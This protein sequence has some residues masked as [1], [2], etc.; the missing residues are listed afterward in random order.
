M[1]STFL[2]VSLTLSEYHTS[3]SHP[4]EMLGQLRY[5]FFVTHAHD[6]FTQWARQY[7][8]IFSLKVFTRTI[9]VLSS[10]SAI[11]EILDTK[12]T[13]T[14]ARPY[15]ILVQRATNGSL[16]ALENP[17]N[18]IWK[19]GRK[20]ITSSFLSK[21]RLPT[22]LR[23]QKLES[24]HLM[25]DLLEDP[26]HVYDHIGRTTLSVLTSLLYGLRITKD[27]PL[28]PKTYFRSV[29]LLNEGLD[30]G[31]HP[32]VDSFWPL[33]YVP[34]Q[35]AYWKRFADSTRTIRDELYTSLHARC[36]LDIKNN[37]Q[38]G[39]YIESLILS[40][41]D[42]KLS[43]DDI[44]GLG[45]MILDAGVETSSSF[46]QSLM[47]SL[48]ANP[49][50]QS[51]AQAEIDRTVG[52]DRL[53]DIED[54]AHTP[55]IRALI[56]E[57]FRFCSILPVGL[58]HVAT[59]DISFK[60]Y[61][62]PRDS[63]IFMNVHGLYH[64]PALFD[65][66]ETF[67]PERFIGN[68]FGTKSDISETELASFRKTFPFGAGRRICPGESLARRTIALNTMNLL[69]GFDFQKDSSGTGNY[70]LDSFS[71]VR[72]AFSSIHALLSF[73]D[74]W[75]VLGSDQIRLT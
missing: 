6:R 47:L 43:R 38:T 45:T 72:K 49:I 26:T 32:P 66:P 21:D 12:S 7:G 55:Y 41:Q 52:P 11:K 22:Q 68:E 63:I 37:T 25:H 73:N 34:Q 2:P 56:D 29:K 46:L 27:G 24:L 30:P 67:D 16:L 9:I 13:Q 61:R 48:L 23:A 14:S 69:W 3:R 42:L 31:A 4:F 44:I 50:V 40:Q 5:C 17:E 15:S 65:N 71:K 19:H 58:P 1:H 53:P 33:Q 59:T 36:E 35:W 60:R 57:A 39:S 54:F 70:D 74:F 64:D 20:L 8:E 75:S 51:T 18:R 62:I 28:H 10:P